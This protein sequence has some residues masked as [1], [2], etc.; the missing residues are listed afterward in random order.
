MLKWLSPEPT[1]NEAL[2]AELK[3][4]VARVAQLGAEAKSR[5]VTVWL[6]TGQGPSSDFFQACNLIWNEAYRTNTEKL[7]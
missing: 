2:I 6:K 1:P 5:G 7:G 3:E 4:A